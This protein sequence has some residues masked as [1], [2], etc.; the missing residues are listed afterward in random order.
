[1]LL[2]TLLM[3]NQWLDSLSHLSASSFFEPVHQRIFEAIERAKA[4]GHEANPI[5]L[6]RQFEQDDSLQAIGGG[7]YLANLAAM[8]VTI[9]DPSEVGQLVYNSANLRR[10]HEICREGLSN[11]ER[12]ELGAEEIASEISIATSEMLGR[13]EALR[14][15]DGRE[16]SMAI[17]EDMKLPRSV[18]STGLPALDEAMGGGLFS[19][20][21]Y[22]FC[23]RKKV[24]KTTLAG[25]LSYNLA[26]RGVKHLFICGEMGAK[27]IQERLLSRRMNVFPSAFRSNYAQSPEF[28]TRLADAVFQVPRAG[29]YQDAPGLSFDDLKRFITAAVSKQKIRGFI[30]DYWQ[31]VGGKTKGQSEASHLEEVAQWIANASRK[32]GIWSV[33][34]GQLNQ[35]GNT[36]GSEGLR[37]ACDQCYALHR[38]DTSAPSA[39]LEMMETRYTP[40]ANIGAGDEKTVSV[41][42]LHMNARGPFF[43][44]A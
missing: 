30:L 12:G 36:R 19:G 39:W 34:L 41:P 17:L 44:Q 10:L 6:K 1:M 4:Q 9:I 3:N 38:P 33:V 23:A 15:M 22:G 26:E 8:A 24:G 25:T 20:R 13:Q 37:L 35:D 18:D 2:G 16:V 32:M 40:W 11:V 43:E 7:R 42:G 5:T 31:L 29:I 28:Q 14:T 27:E 21:T